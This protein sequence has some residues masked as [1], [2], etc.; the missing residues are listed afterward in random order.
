MWSI[1]KSNRAYDDIVPWL[2]ANRCPYMYDVETVKAANEYGIYR[3]P[4]GSDFDGDVYEGGWKDG[5]AYGQGTYTF[6]DDDVFKDDNQHKQGVYTY[7]SGQGTVILNLITYANGEVY[8]GGF[9]YGKK[10]GQGKNT[11]ANDL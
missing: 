1:V 11:Y 2:Q 5:K 7:A 6:S 3:Y 9:K 8:V 4:I 10:H